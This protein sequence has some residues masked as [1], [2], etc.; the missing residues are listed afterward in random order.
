MDILLLFD[1]DVYNFKIITKIKQA[2][3]N[4]F[5]EIG[6]YC[7]PIYGYIQNINDDKAVLLR[8][9]IGYGVLL[10]GDDI[11][12]L[13]LQETPEQQKQIEY[14]RNFANNYG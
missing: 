6:I 3:K 14:A 7:D 8:Q 1:K 13:M 4:D 12:K 2:I 9:Y 10:Y 11:S 5:E